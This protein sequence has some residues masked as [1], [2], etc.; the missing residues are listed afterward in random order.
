MAAIKETSDADF[1]ADVLKNEKTVLVDFWA[2][3]CGPCRAVAPILEEI[4]A[5]NAGSIEI[6]KLNTD[7]NPKTAAKYG[8]VSIPTMNVFQGGEIVKTIVGAHPKPKLLR[9]IA[10]FIA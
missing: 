2:P 3:W 6:I 5:E 9:E 4:A 8:I 10:D 7:E 1:E